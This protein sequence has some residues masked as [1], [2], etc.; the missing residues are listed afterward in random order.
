MAAATRRVASL[1]SSIKTAIERDGCR[2]R[3]CP[4]GTAHSTTAG[5][6]PSFP[7]RPRLPSLP[8]IWSSRVEVRRAETAAASLRSCGPAGSTPAGAAD[9]G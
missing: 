2:T 4:C 3:T 9:D 5:L 1:R 7:C 8:G 6:A